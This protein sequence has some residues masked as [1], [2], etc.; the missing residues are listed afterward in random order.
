MYLG[1]Y[2]FTICLPCLNLYMCP[3]IMCAI[4][5]IYYWLQYDIKKENV[6]NK[7]L[8][9][10]KNVT[11]NICVL[12]VANLIFLEWCMTHCHCPIK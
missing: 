12:G 11:R 7:Y 6:K 5:Y 9:Q 8:L 10:L 2:N 4:L 3:T 1:K